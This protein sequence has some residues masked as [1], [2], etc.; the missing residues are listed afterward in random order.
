MHVLTNSRLRLPLLILVAIAARALTFGNPVVHV[1]EEFYFVTGSAL[2]RG[3]L[4]FVDVWDRKPVGLFLLYALPAGLGFPAGI[5]AYQALALASAVATAWL[6]A[7]LATRAGFAAGATA[8]GIGY[9]LWLGLLGGQGGQSP[10]FYNLLTIGAALLVLRGGRAAGIAAMALVGV[11]LQIKYSVVFEGVFFG[12]WLLADAWPRTRR[13]LAVLT[14]GVMLIVVALLPTALAAAAYA[15]IGQGQAF[16]YAN[17]LSIFHRNPDP[18]GELAGNL[19]QIVLVIS[20]LVALAVLALHRAEATR[21]RRFLALWLGVAIAGV[22]VFRPWFDHYSLPVLL[23][24]CAAA[25]GMLGRGDWQ[26]WRTPALLLTA[27]LAGQIVLVALRGERGDARQF[28]ALAQAVGRGPGCLYVYSGSTMLYV[29]SGRCTSSRYI[30]PSHLGRTR[31]AG[32]TGV[33]QDGE[34]RRILAGQPAVVVMR[35]PYGGERP[36]ARALAM[37]TMATGYRLAAALPMG[38]ETI[39]VYKRAR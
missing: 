13:P 9:I 18:L 27:A 33:D 32:A 37:A 4:P 3:M 34:I 29:A 25:A 15:A 10:V 14:Y 39:S 38:N 21:E 26:R 22:L 20:P 19:G 16:V 31:E 12:L 8:A 30:V 1:D 5:W 6:V 36:Q 2:W 11:A 24:A 17:F 23:P 7:R 35:P 28:A